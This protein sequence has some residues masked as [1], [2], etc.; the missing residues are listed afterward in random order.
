[1]A[2]DSLLIPVLVGII[3]IVFGVRN[4]KG[5]ITTLHRYHRKRVSEEDRIPF[6][7]KVGSGT[8]I[9]GCSVI[10]K[11]CSQFTAEKLSMP[12]LETLGTVILIAGLAI[13]FALIIYA[14]IKYNKG[15]F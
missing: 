9:I 5:D 13:G 8:I 1:M 4:L 10:A 14:L 11:A 2:M 3:V 7:R 6:G 15:L 12:W